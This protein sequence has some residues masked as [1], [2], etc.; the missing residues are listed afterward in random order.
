MNFRLKKVK[1]LLV[2]TSLLTMCVLPVQSSVVSA[3]T[4]DIGPWQTATNSLTDVVA[5]ATTSTANNYVYVIGGVNSEEIPLSTV[6]YAPLNPDGTLGVWN[7]STPLPEARFYANSVIYNGFVYV[8]GGGANGSDHGSTV[9][10]APL[11]S[12]GT[13]GAWNT[14]ANSLPSGVLGASS[15]LVNNYVYVLGG[16]DDTSLAT[17]TVYYAPLNPDGT[18]G[19]WNTATN[20]LPAAIFGQ[21]SVTSNGYIYSFGGYSFDSGTSDHQFYAPVNTDGSI[22]DWITPSSNPLPSGRVLASSFIANGYVYVMNG[23]SNPA[24]PSS[25]QSTVLFAKLSSDGSYGQWVVSDNET[26]SPIHA[27]GA[28]VA[29]GF[30]Y[31]IGGAMFD[32]DGSLIIPSRVY[33]TPIAQQPVTAPTDLSAITPTNQKPFLSWDSVNQ[34]NSY[35]IYRD[36]NQ[37]GTSTATSFT[38][39]LLSVDGSYVYTVSA[40][41]LNGIESA[42]SSSFIVVYDTTSPTTG[43]PVMSGGHVNQNIGYAFTPNTTSS[44][45]SAVVA[46]NLSGIALIEYYFDTDPGQGNGTAMIVS[47]SNATATATISNLS[48]GQHTL[49]IRSQD[50][51]GNW[52][53]V[54]SFTFT[55]LGR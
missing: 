32:S 28:I 5:G 4:G 24:D 7:T 49:H 44:N 45:I 1:T 39:S 13:V 23:V 16:V 41:G 18:V 27:G 46:D 47:G 38:D 35:T 14:A 25:L 42:Q 36:G 53:S 17:S 55:R 9:Y 15:V 12:D 11:N 51:A 33:Y 50:S 3:L 48:S 43:T 30:A 2:A 37:V 22:G 6:R 31:A 34:A 10:Y 20:S 40:T 52:S 29:N 19:A 21:T 26:P 8:I 54:A